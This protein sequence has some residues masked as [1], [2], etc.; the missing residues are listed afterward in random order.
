[1]S[2][3][4]VRWILKTPTEPL[5]PGKGSPIGS[6]ES[7]S[8]LGDASVEGC[9]DH[10]AAGRGNTDVSRRGSGEYFGSNAVASLDSES[11]GV[12]G[13]VLDLEEHS[14]PVNHDLS[15]CAVGGVGG[16]CGRL[17]GV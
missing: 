5:M 14:V 7:G 17:S 13:P 6:R 11:G 10:D 3:P 15:E 16:W 8:S 9:R 2:D 12:S 4:S 1:M